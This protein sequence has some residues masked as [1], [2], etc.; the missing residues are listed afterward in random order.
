MIARFVLAVVGVASGW[1]L[2][3]PAVAEEDPRVQ[4]Q[5]A[6]QGGL[7]WLAARQVAD[8]P[9]AGSWEAGEPRYRTA[10][11]SL[12]GLAFLAN[13]HLPGEGP[14]G[15]AIERAMAYVKPSMASDG[16]LG[17]GDRS[18]MYI[19][20]ICTLFGLSYLG[21]SREAATDTELADWCRR[22]LRLIVEA[23]KVSRLDFAR[24]GWRYT[25]YTDESDVSVTSWQLL[26]LHA[27]RQCGYVIEEDGPDA[28]IR[29]INSAFVEQ[30]G[31]PA[32][33]GGAAGFVYRPGVSQDPEPAATGAAI[34][35][36]SLLERHADERVV[37][38]LGF[39]GAYPPSWG[40]EQYGGYFFFSAFY[41]TQGMFQI[42]D[43]AWEGYMA[44]MRGILV[45]HQAGD[46]SWPYPPDDVRQ[47]QLAGA[48]YPTA[49]AV[50]ILSLEKQYLPMYQRQAAMFR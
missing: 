44:P 47:S 19:H 21:M 18:G 24:G 37:K 17:R 46:G 23:Q 16:Y 4:A 32:R 22:S 5:S 25:P 8:G 26:V 29:F 45:D 27:A 48:A 6:I 15:R 30:A 1:A 34:F 43:A 49:M 50:L 33:A 39:L 7:K 31:T 9:E 42:G 36:K 40:G 20:A 41:M 3:G 13:G 11:A 35:I 38:S 2:C 28:A 12:A 14:Y 10:V